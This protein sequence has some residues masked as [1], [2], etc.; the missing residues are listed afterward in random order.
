MLANI[1]LLALSLLAG[2]A[3]AAP[4]KPPHAGTGVNDPAYRWSV[5]DWSAG[6]GRAGCYYY[7]NI[8][9]PAYKHIPAFSAYC[10]GAPEDKFSKPCGVNDKLPGNRGVSAHL[11]E[12][13]Q[14]TGAHIE[15][16]FQWSKLDMPSTYYNY[17]GNAT[18][19]YN[20]FV[21]PLQ[22][23][24]ITPSSAFGVA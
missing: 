7:F 8:S 22:K 10:S 16:S 17:T 21:A 15:V 13:E 9:A 4:P 1:N 23:F 19:I 12:A 20:Q 2:T 5:T 6:C 24:T 18:T 11:L 3:L 14:G